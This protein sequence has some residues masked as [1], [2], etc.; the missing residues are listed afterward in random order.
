MLEAIVVAPTAFEA[1]ALSAAAYLS[2]MNKDMGL[3]GSISDI[4]GIDIYE[5]EEGGIEIEKSYGMEAFFVQ[6]V[7]PLS[8]LNTKPACAF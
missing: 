6:K 4:E 5:R 2:G 1:D 7:E 3:I 8:Q